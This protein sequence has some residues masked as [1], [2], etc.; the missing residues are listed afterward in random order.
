M[1]NFLQDNWVLLLGFAALLAVGV[2]VGSV[3]RNVEA[4]RRAAAAPAATPRCEDCPC[5]C[6]CARG[7]PCECVAC[8][9]GRCP[10]LAKSAK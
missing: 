1:K 2:A 9:C 4:D 6:P 5:D 7:K 8:E 10:G 3:V